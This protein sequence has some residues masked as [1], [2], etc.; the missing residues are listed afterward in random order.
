MLSV[1]I[2]PSC[3]V[4]CTKVVSVLLKPPSWAWTILCETGV[5]E[6][7]LS[8]PRQALPSTPR[9]PLQHK[10]RG[11][12][13]EDL[14]SNWE[15]TCDWVLASKISLWEILLEPIFVQVV[16]LSPAEIGP[17]L[18]LLNKLL[19]YLWY[20]QLPVPELCNVHKKH[21]QCFK[22]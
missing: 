7:I 11:A 19:W 14:P 12:F 9:T 13:A 21:L 16:R 1:S 15:T 3:L 5:D 17:F 20:A 2:A 4:P 22:L 10:D 18:T 8:T 6:G